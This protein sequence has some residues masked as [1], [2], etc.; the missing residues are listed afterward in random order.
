MPAYR[1]GRHYGCRVILDATIGGFR[2]VFLENEQLRVTVLAD[3]GA[4][5]QEFLHKPTDTDFLWRS[6]MGLRHPTLN[7]SPP[8]AN[9]GEW[10]DYYEGG[11]QDLFPSGSSASSYKG[12]DFGFH[13]ESSTAPWQVDLVTDSPEEV[14]VRFSLYT[15]RSPFYAERVLSLRRG[16]PVLR[17]D[18]TL[19]NLGREEMD[20]MWGHHPA[21]GAPFLSGDCAIDLPTVGRV[22]VGPEPYFERQRVK[23]GGGAEWPWAEGRLGGRVDMSL[24]PGPEVETADVLGL[25]GLAA[26]WYAVTDRRRRIS[27]GL[28]WPVEVMPWLWFWQVCHGAY[29]Y[30]WYGRA[31]V[32]A[33]EP[34]T[35]PPGPGLGWAAANGTAAKV[36]AGGSISARIMAVAAAGY[37]RVTGIDADGRVSGE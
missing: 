8:S 35:T 37:T 3:K 5:I 9:G 23:P 18:E 1:P 10:L 25:T 27:F 16:E 4:D 6:P 28:A 14:A 30:P 13:G 36:P 22:W 26:G 12:A 29:G 11:W 19:T 2:A 7:V 21:L 20:L 31:Y 33:L 34:W 15:C 32:M 24:V 17:V